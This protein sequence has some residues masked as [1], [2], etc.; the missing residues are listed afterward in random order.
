MMTDKEKY[1][2]EMELVN[3]ISLAKIFSWKTI[4]ALFK[5]NAIAEDK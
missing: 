4:K 3:E 2:V 5:L 1:E